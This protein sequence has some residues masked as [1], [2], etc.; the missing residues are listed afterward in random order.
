MI[1]IITVNWD[2]YDFLDLLIESLDIFSSMPHELIVIDNS[3]NKQQ[4][5]NVL[6]FYMNENIGH[7]PGLNEGVKHAKYPFI[8][9]LDVDTHFL[10]HGWEKYFLN[11]MDE[12]DV[13]GGKGV[14]IKPIRP[15][16]MFLK[17][18]FAHY[19]WRATDGYKGHK[20]TPEGMDVAIPAYYQMKKDGVKIGL[21]E[22]GPNRYGTY[23]GEEWIISETPLV[24]HHWSG[25]WLPIRQQEDFPDFD[26]DLLKEKEK[27]FS[28]IPWRLP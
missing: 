26:V 5:S 4:R 8:M 15:S 2:S 16:C 3:T 20:I 28:N 11:M 9:F 19:D 10:C 1:S 12:F 23:T 18:E 7:G 21:F 27:L 13:I 25:T 14:E 6:Q 17:R 24:Y 22:N